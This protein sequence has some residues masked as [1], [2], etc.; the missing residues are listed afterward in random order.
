MNSFKSKSEGGGYENIDLRASPKEIEEKQK[1]LLQKAKDEYDLQGFIV[2][3]ERDSAIWQ[4]T[5][6]ANDGS[7]IERSRQ[8]LL[9]RLFIVL[10]YGGLLF[11]PDQKENNWQFW[12][13]NNMPIATALS[14]G[15][16]VMI[17]LPKSERMAALKS[18]LPS[19]KS[20]S[21][22]RVGF[23]DER[24]HD[25]GFWRWLVTGTSSG[26]LSNYIS[27]STNGDAA[28]QEGKIL[29]RR[30]GA[31][32]GITYKEGEGTRIEVNNEIRRKEIVEKKE[33]LGVNHRNT[34]LLGTQNTLLTKHR[35]WGCNLAIGGIGNPAFGVHT[36][37]I[38]PD[39]SHGHLYLYYMSPGE[40]RFGGILVGVEGSEYGKNDQSGE[41]HGLSAK[42][43]PLSITMGYKWN[44]LK[45]IGS[46]GLGGGV[47]DKYDS[48]FVDLTAGWSHIAGGEWLDDMVGETSLTSS[49][50]SA[51]DDVY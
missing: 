51:L 3:T 38:I 4:R 41:S 29:F 35:H 34:K 14:H 45:K 33:H 13:A 47:P 8:N 12:S 2:Q 21:E 39:G 37:N 32:H 22:S 16:R 30:L 1:M 24:N 20:T 19:F 25:H 26:D 27:T 7:D 48:M 28:R 40:K 44:Q 5:L 43:S 18:M 6:S 10:R 49:P 15:S 17:Q 9:R 50:F 42:S 11:R 23:T 36:G 46:E 31:T